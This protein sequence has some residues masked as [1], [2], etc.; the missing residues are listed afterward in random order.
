MQ[1]LDHRRTVLERYPRSSKL[2]RA[3]SKF[4]LDVKNDP[5][6]SAK[7]L[8]E[9]EKLEEIAENAAQN[10]GGTLEGSTRIDE[11][12][13]AV[14]II[15]AEGTIEFTNK[16]LQ[17][18]FGFSSRDAL[19]GKNISCLMTQPFSQQHN[20]YLRNY[21]Q[22][23]K[24]RILKQV[25]EVVGLHRKGYCFPIT[26]FVNKVNQAGSEGFLGVIKAIPEETG[27]GRVWLT[28]AGN[29][30]CVS[31]GFTDL[32]GYRPEQVTGR[33]LGAYSLDAET[34][35]QVL[36][37]VKTTD[38][39]YAGSGATREISFRH[40]F[41]GHTRVLC[42][43]YFAG[44]ETTRMNVLIMKPVDDKAG[45]L[46]VSDEGI[47][48][49]SDSRLC[50]MLGQEAAALEG[51]GLDAI[52]PRPMGPLHS[53][54]WLKK[55]QVAGLDAPCMNERTIPLKG[56]TGR[57]VHVVFSPIRPLEGEEPGVGAKPLKSLHHSHSQEVLYAF[58]V[59]PSSY[60]TWMAEQRVSL[61]LAEPGT[62]TSAAAPPTVATLEFFAS[63]LQG[64]SIATFV[65][66]LE[67][68]TCLKALQGLLE[69]GT[70]STRAL[71]KAKSGVLP[72]VLEFERHIEGLAVHV[73]RVD[74]LD[75]TLEVGR[76][77]GVIIDSSDLAHVM[78]GLT[79]DELRQCTMQQLLPSAFRQ[80]LQ[81]RPEELLNNRT[82]RT[83]IS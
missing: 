65:D 21:A 37:E 39:V 26:I 75:M 60:D 31:R 51:K 22:T 28:P 50:A 55:R 8:T 67:P 15:S 42:S 45:C 25:R 36:A 61:V 1:Q 79:K 52:L 14:I 3:Y 62:I 20:S 16:L 66:G 54:A 71:W 11:L 34:L 81:S 64:Q 35:S 43:A 74:R 76:H 40:C 77:T 68:A 78:F 29:V 12:R 49:F 5:G 23:G 80:G 24:A 69:S 4:L 72:T 17:S 13:D 46:V 48:H 33:Y 2:L 70:R 53:A 63:E 44:T 18:M 83:D 30:L 56:P 57:P 6:T 32:L 82:R 59:L 7:Y 38:S 19:E 10:Y 41:G 9:A 47:I 73:Y 27:I 58:K